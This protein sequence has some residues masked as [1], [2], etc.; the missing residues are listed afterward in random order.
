MHKNIRKNGHA[1]KD[2]YRDIAQIRSALSHA[3]Q[4]IKGQAEDMISHSWMI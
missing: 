1:A 3:G 4:G 2:L